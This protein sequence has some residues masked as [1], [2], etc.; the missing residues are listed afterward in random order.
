[1]ALIASTPTSVKVGGVFS[2]I[3]KLNTDIAAIT[4]KSG[5]LYGKVCDVSGGSISLG[6]EQE[7]YA[8]NINSDDYTIGQTISDKFA[9]IY[10]KI[11][12]DTGSEPVIVARS[13]NTLT[14]GTPGS[15]FISTT[16]CVSP[17]LGVGTSG[18]VAI[19][20]Y[21]ANGVNP[22]L[23]DFSISGDTITTGT[24]ESP[25]GLMTHFL[26]ATGMDSDDVMIMGYDNSYNL[27]FQMVNL[28]S[29]ISQG[30]VSD[31]THNL[32]STFSDVWTSALGRLTDTKAICVFPRDNAT[33]ALS[34]MTINRSGTSISSYG[35]PTDIYTDTGGGIYGGAAIAVI[36]SSTILL[37]YRDASGDR[38]V[39]TF[40]I[41]GDTITANG[42]TVSV[43]GTWSSIGGIAIL[44]TN[45]AVICWEDAASDIQAVLV[46]G[47]SGP[48][49][50]LT[51]SSGGIPGAILVT[52]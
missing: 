41:S 51:H 39:Q 49:Y 43:S 30:T 34:L 19:A 48:D 50:A 26:A 23:C 25:S 20:G 46:T 35:T 11:I 18:T 22:Q 40:S 21:R 47:F 24:P 9:M 3:C 27:Y 45:E 4:Y 37:F 28:T 5:N 44:D 10:A 7:I 42:D 17:A 29:G 31:S 12:T 33:D 6:T 32:V 13:G 15:E 14:E 16:P 52:S 2:R 38:Q 8:G 1:M 36:D